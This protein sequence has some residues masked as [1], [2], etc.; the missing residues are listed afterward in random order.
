MRIAVALLLALATFARAE[1]SDT[2]RAV[3]VGAMI[4]L[5]GVYLTMEFP[6]NH[7]F[8]PT[9]CVWCEPP[10]FDRR[11]REALRWD[12]TRLPGI[13][14]DILG[15]AVAPTALGLM[16]LTASGDHRTWRRTLDDAA[17]MIEAAFGVSLLQSVT[18]Y[19]LPRSRPLVRYAKPGRAYYHRDYVSFWSGH[20]S[21][22]FAETFACGIVASARGYKLAPAI[23]ATGISIG[24]VTGYLRLAADQH[25]ASDVVFGALI[26]IGVGIAVPYLIHGSSLERDQDATTMRTAPRFL[27]F[28][29]RF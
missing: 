5:T 26:G 14:S 15:F 20:T 7:W 27:S 17:P 2:S 12:N 1:P 4:T 18:K 3:H 16:M 29:G 22:V 21:A 6:V 10:A 25:Y 11:I 8:A 19:L 24:V 9:K 13:T 28:G 23:W